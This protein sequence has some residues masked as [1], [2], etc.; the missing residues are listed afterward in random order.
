MGNFHS[1]IFKKEIVNENFEKIGEGLDG[2]IISP[3]IG[4]L[5]KFLIGKLSTK[6]KSILEFDLSNKFY[7]VDK[8]K[9]YGIYG[10]NLNKINKNY[11]DKIKSLCKKTIKD[12]INEVYQITMEKF[13]YDLLKL[14]FELFSKLDK[15]IFEDNYFRLTN[16]I[17]G[18][19]IFHNAGLYHMDIRKPNIALHNNVLKLFDWGRSITKNELHLHAKKVQPNSL[20]FL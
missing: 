2:C 6:Q 11:L 17:K 19:S 4:S 20:N 7:K 12:D 13:D 16:L 9:K 3:P 10:L 14:H 15:F 1:I 5:D 8:E 18:I